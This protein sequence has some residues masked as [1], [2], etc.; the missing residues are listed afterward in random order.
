MISRAIF[1]AFVISIACLSGVCLSDLTV[2]DV[3]DWESFTV[4]STGGTHHSNSVN[5]QSAGYDIDAFVKFDLAGLP[6][7]IS[8]TGAKLISKC[9]WVGTPVTSSISIYRTEDD[10]WQSGI[11]GISDTYPGLDS[12]LSST[13]QE[14]VK[15]SVYAWDLDLAGFDW[16]TDFA[17]GFLTIGMS[18]NDATSWWYTADTKLEVEHVA[19]PTPTAVLL[20]ALGLGV[21]GAKLRRRRGLK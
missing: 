1:P 12:L 18:T 7:G 9:Y 2:L 21:A 10:S 16:A 5:I 3:Q 4:G 13:P 15:E 6:D 20:G 17:D 19:A 11:A 8:V 14:L